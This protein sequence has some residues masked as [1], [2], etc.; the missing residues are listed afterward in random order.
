MTSPFRIRYQLDHRF[1]GG[2]LSAYLDDELTDSQKSRLERHLAVCPACRQALAS[3]RDTVTLLRRTPARPVPRSFTLPA[4]VQP[5]QARNRRWNLAYSY[6]RGAT[7]VTSFLFILLV[8]GD[9]LIGMGA[10]PIPDAVA[11]REKAVALEAM[12]ESSAVVETVVVEREAPAAAPPTEGAAVAEEAPAPGEQPKMAEE[13]EATP[14]ARPT[15]SPGADAA[16]AGGEGEAPE[17]AAVPATSPDMPR[18][19]DTQMVESAP[20]MKGLVPAP[21]LNGRGVEPTPTIRP[22]LTPTAVTRE[23]PTATPSRVPATIVRRLSPATH[24]P[25]ATPAR[26]AAHL[27]PQVESQVRGVGPPAA[28]PLSPMWTIWRRVR[29]LWGLLAGLLLVLL[30]GTIWAGHKRRP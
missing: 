13:C 11:P 19:E 25:S 2:N 7:V 6:L 12:P 8:S 20:A 26:V 17:K 23:P 16:F 3:L 30:A 21:G 22:T 4:S 15:P 28:R 10:I 29:I 14:E 27:T 1:A 24:E 5:E 18:R 9:A